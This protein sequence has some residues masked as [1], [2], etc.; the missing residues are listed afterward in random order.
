MSHLPDCHEAAVCTV[1]APTSAAAQAF[2]L[3]VAAQ[4][5]AYA[6]RT[7]AVALV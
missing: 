4:L 2:T 5:L 6:P 3:H 7:D 1:L